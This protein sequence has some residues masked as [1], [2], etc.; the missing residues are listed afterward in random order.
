MKRVVMLLGCILLLTTLLAAADVTGKWKGQFNANGNDVSLTL[1]L[2][3]AGDTLT[4]TINGLPTDPCE[5]KEGKVQG[6]NVSFSIT[7][8]YQGQPLKL[9]YKGKVASDAIQ[10]TMGIED[11]SWSTDFVVKRST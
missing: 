9:V 3:A 6:D 7:I 2:T 11:G 1:N 5:I 4:G 8:E 10:F